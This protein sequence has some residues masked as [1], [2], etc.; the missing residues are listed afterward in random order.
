MAVPVKVI[1]LEDDGTVTDLLE[2]VECRSSDEDVIKVGP[3]CF[4]A[5][6]E[7]PYKTVTF[8]N[9]TSSFSFLTV[10]LLRNKGLLSV[11]GRTIKQTENHILFCMSNTWNC[12]SLPTFEVFSELTLPLP[13][14][15]QLYGL[16]GCQKGWQIF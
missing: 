6:R 9:V 10:L 11:Y 1:S 8:S 4:I 12:L 13:F 16:C 3:Y 2:S 5:Q 15:S 14:T 7:R